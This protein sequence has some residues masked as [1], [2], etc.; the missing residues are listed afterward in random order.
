[1]C[2]ALTNK[3]AQDSWFVGGKALGA[4]LWVLLV[5]ALWA[6]V[7]VDQYTPGSGGSGALS[8]NAH[9]AGC[10][11]DQ[12]IQ[13]LKNTHALFANNPSRAI[14]FGALS[15]STPRVPN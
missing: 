4:A 9:K 14:P 12:C 1:M 6:L 2:P 10:I 3:G 13:A 11:V 5:S 7:I 8:I 15:I